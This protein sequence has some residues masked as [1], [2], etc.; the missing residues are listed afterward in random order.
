MMMIITGVVILAIATLKH[1]RAMRH[2]RRITGRR[3]YSVVACYALLLPL[4]LIAYVKF[5]PSRRAAARTG[6]DG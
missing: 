6:N 5:Q 2:F 3:V 1:Y 4:V